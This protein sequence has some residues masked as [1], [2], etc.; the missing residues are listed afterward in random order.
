MNHIAKYTAL[1]TGPQHR[2]SQDPATASNCS[3]NSYFRR[4][5]TY[6]GCPSHPKSLESDVLI[7]SSG[8]C[9]QVPVHFVPSSDDLMTWWNCTAKGSHQRQ[10]VPGS[11]RRSSFDSIWNQSLSFSSMT[12]QHPVYENI[13]RKLPRPYPSNHPSDH[14]PDHPSDHHLTYS[15]LDNT[16]TIS[17]TIY[18]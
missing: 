11:P 13:R 2:I 4:L 7:V 17:N 18:Y 16:N 14:P 15:N 5:W 6:L 10:P 3:L 1:P 12:S 9:Q 8:I